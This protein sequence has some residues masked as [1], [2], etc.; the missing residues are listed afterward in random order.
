MQNVCY[1]Y[2]V[3]YL[4][5][6]F[7]NIYLYLILIRIWHLYCRL[8]CGLVY[9]S[10]IWI[11]DT[12]VR[13]TR[14]WRKTLIL[15]GTVHWHHFL[16]HSLKWSTWAFGVCV[17]RQLDCLRQLVVVLCE[18]AQL[19]DLVQFSFVNLH[20]EVCQNTL[21]C[22]CLK[23]SWNCTDRRWQTTIGAFVWFCQIGVLLQLVSVPFVCCWHWSVYVG[24]L[25]IG[26]Y[27]YLLFHLLLKFTF[28]DLISFH[29]SKHLMLTWCLN[30]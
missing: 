18:R 11:L 23:A 16:I 21:S 24:T 10:I 30:M 28:M 15:A 19:R 6:N 4:K 17:C 2:I 27:S 5:H 7:E 13:H 26:L 12:T 1:P 22:M 29:W 14:L 8:L 25:W 3:R 20:D 9:S